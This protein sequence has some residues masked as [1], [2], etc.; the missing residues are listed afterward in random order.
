MN[1]AAREPLCVLGEFLQQ[2]N[3]P[4]NRICY[5]IAEVLYFEMLPCRYP[6]RGERKREEE[7]ESENLSLC[8]TVGSPV[9]KGMV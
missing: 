5:P 2:D 9:T 4:Q 8:V 6:G 3:D 7:G 1:V